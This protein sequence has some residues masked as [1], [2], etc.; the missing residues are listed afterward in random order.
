MTASP[1]EYRTQVV[2]LQYST[3]RVDMELGRRNGLAGRLVR[4]VVRKIVG[5]KESIVPPCALNAAQP[6][7]LALHRH[8]RHALYVV[9]MLTPTAQ[10]LLSLRFRCHY[11]IGIVTL[12][13]FSLM[14]LS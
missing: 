10:R 11:S 6:V 4:A 7:C 3:R 5:H 1:L 8:D 12:L 9:A 2:A 13:S 14:N